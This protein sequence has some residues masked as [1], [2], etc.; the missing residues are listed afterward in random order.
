MSE[1][2]ESARA[3]NVSAAASRAIPSGSRRG[4]PLKIRLSTIA[5]TSSTA[6]RSSSIEW[7]I[8]PVMSST[9]TGSP[10]MR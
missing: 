4:R 6:T 5:M 1:A 2:P 10:V 8:E 7:V 3:P 9:I